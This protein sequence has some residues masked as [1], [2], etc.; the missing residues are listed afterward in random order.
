MKK[1]SAAILSVL[2]L[3]LAGCGEEPAVPEET[4]PSVPTGVMV[5]DSTE[6]SLRFQWDAMEGAEKYDWKLSLAGTELQSGTVSVRN[7]TVSGL[8]Q[9]VTYSFA[10]RSVKGGLTSGYCSPVE[11]RTVAEK[12]TPPDPV[13]PVDP[14]SGDVYARFLI[15]EAEEDGIPR[16]FPGAEGGGMYTTGGRGGIVYHVT[17]LADDGSKGTLRYGL[18]MKRSDASYTEPPLTIVFDVAGRIELKSTL[19]IHYGNLTIAGQTA[20]G[21]GICISGYSTVIK[22]DADNI[23]IRFMRFRMGDENKIEDD[24]IWGRYAGNIILDHCSMSWSTDECSSFYA[25]Y[26]FTMQWCLLTESLCNSVHG[27]GAHG[28][29]GIW[30][31]KDASFHHNMLSGHK[32]RTPRFDHQY[33]YDGNGKSTD[34][35]R[36]NVDYRNCVNYNW[37]AG[38]GCYGGE[39]GRFNMV[40]NY[41]KPGPASSDRP[42]FI[43]ADGGYTTGGKTYAYDWA[44]L[45]LSDN[46]NTAHPEGSDKYP[47]GV[48]WKKAYADYSL[49]YEGHVLSAPLPV[50]GRNGAAA[51]TTT[52]SAQ[53]AFTLVCAYAGASLCRDRVDERA[54]KDAVSG[55]VTFNDGGNGSTGGIIDTQGAVGGWPSYTAD[56]GQLALAADTDK[57]GIPDYYEALFGLNGEDASDA[58]A[59]SLDVNGRYTNLEMYLHWLVKDIVAEQNKN[60]TYTKL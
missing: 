55:T 49:S 4:A 9:G 19:E 8:S 18:R 54:A 33:L 29:G 30:G 12:T 36:G 24:S 50:S 10:V 22:P 14:L 2:M 44:Y 26:N 13:D 39:G 47:D 28:Y 6:T 21:A 56:E 37:G 1:L 20:P 52:H 7:V 16:A 15:P 23:I 59:V 46:F 17:S 51:Y 38:N 27:K 32:N 25:N 41:Y 43:E 34:T 53:D 31:G 57:D 5:H 48:Y 58:S 35:F 40:G 3:A 45:Y 42:Y 60:G 11:G